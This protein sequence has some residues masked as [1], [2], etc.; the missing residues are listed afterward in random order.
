MA[1]RHNRRRVLAALVITMGM[2]MVSLVK[3]VGAHAGLLPFYMVGTIGTTSS[4][5]VDP[6]G[7]MGAIAQKYK[8][9]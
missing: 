1:H 9:W 7:E 4:C 2:R 6:I 5:A 3:R 8:I